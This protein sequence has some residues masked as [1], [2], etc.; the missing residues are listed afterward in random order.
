MPPVLIT[1][2]K[3]MREMSQTSGSDNVFNENDIVISGV[4][5]DGHSS[6]KKGPALA[7]V[8]IR[9]ALFCASSNLFTENRID[10]GAISAWHMLPDLV[11]PNEEDALARIESETGHLLK[12]K[13]RVISL[14][15]DHSVTLP[16][17][18]AYAGVYPKLNILHLDAHP[19][20]YDELD[21]NRYSHACP[22]ARIMEENLADRLVQAGIRTMTAHQYEQAVRF[23]VEVIEMRHIERARN[24][25]FDGPVYISLDLDGLDPAFAPGVSHHE[26]GG[27]ST[28]DVLEIIQSLEGNIVGADIV[29]YNP[30][31]DIN[32]MTGMV[33]GK[34]LKEL[35][36]KML[37]SMP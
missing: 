20:L 14:G 27:M 17:I 22:F 2:K 21:G 28:R 29:E 36:A 15:G 13:L 32:G 31:R 35:I 1:D 6:Y 19:D 23:E 16:L 34:L 12:K 5:F 10:L 30:E 37:E 9:E 33:A 26:P 24:L 18:R 7:P 3:G 25:S 11:L 4:P 8:R